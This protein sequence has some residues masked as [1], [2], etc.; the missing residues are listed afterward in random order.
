MY[1][2]PDEIGLIW[3]TPLAG[4]RVCLMAQIF[5]GCQGARGY[6]WLGGG[7]PTGHNACTCWDN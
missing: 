1:T 3:R 2:H 5:W 4:V 6:G 7:E